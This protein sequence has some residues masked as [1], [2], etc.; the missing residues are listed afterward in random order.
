[1]IT[2]PVNQDI[3]M[4]ELQISILIDGTVCVEKLKFVL[5]FLLK[6]TSS[7]CESCKKANYETVIFDVMTQFPKC[8]QTL[9]KCLQKVKSHNC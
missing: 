5:V 3:I 4:R 8:L 2:F 1:M 6:K 7:F 9:P